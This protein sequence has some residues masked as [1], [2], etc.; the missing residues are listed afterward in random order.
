MWLMGWAVASAAG[1]GVAEVG[2]TFSPPV[3]VGGATWMADRFW[4]MGPVNGTS[5]SVS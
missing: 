4:A 2:L 5:T 1:R 3:F